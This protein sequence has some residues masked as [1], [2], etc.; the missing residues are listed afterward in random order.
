MLPYGRQSIDASDVAAVVAALGSDWLTTGPRVRQFEADIEAVAGAPAVTVTNGTT[1]LHAAYAAAGV[2]SGDEVITTPMTFV[3][4]ASTA[5]MLGA[6]VVFADVEDETANLDPAAVEALVTGSTRAVT[7]VDYAGHPAEYDA[8]RKVTEPA[9]AVLIG[10]AAHAIG[11]T[12]DGR[13]VGTLADLTTFSFFPT[14]NLTTAEGGAVASTRPDLLERAR[15]FR[16]VGMV[17]DPARLRRPDEGGWFYEVH[18]FGLN[19]RLPDVLCAL[20][21]SQLL[22]LADFKARRQHLTARY[23]ELL[24]DVPGLRLPVQR[25]GVDPMRHLYPVRV[26]DGR[27]REVY[28]RMH[29]AGIG[30]Q[31]N[32][33]PVYWHPVFEDL[34]YR[35]GMCPVAETFYAEELSLPIFHDLTDADQDRVVETLRGILGS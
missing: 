2:G 6:R 13:P 11:S 5:A 16:S 9:G 3:A 25:A 10:D 29:A 7:A 15:T 20:G 24:A 8:L 21:S 22:R 32:Y 18:E 4:T 35:R 17:K 31:V 34:G 12:V 14:K 19:Y 26:L 23:D 30:V 33:I 28:E 27:R 1:A